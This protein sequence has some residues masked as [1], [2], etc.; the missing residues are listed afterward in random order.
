M[1]T[2]LP[3]EWDEALPT[4]VLSASLASVAVIRWS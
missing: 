3:S 1:F 4:S 2:Q